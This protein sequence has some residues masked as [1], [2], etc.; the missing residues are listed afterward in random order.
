MLVGY[1]VHLQKQN[2]ITRTKYDIRMNKGKLKGH[3]LKLNLIYTDP[4]YLTKNML[5]TTTNKLFVFLIINIV[6]LI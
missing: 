1:S 5:I 3:R 4:F 6:T 2:K